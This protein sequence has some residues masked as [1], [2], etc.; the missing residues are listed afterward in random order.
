MTRG[1]H[2]DL[3]LRNDFPSLNSGSASPPAPLAQSRIRRSCPPAAKLFQEGLDQ[4]LI[5]TGR[6]AAPSFPAAQGSGVD[7]KQA[8]QHLLAEAPLP[9]VG[10]EALAD[11]GVSGSWRGSD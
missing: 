5:P 2:R 7:A 4:P 6:N 9:P 1:G 8:G 10:D 3:R 11:R